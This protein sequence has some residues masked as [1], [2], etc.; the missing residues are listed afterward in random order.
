MLKGKKIVLGV[1]GSIAAYKAVF[2]LRELVKRGADVHV[3]VTDNAKE[4]IAPLTF[5]VLSGNTVFNDMFDITGTDISHIN[6]QEDTDI[7]VV[8]PATAN[9]IGKFA[10]GV[11]DDFLSTFFLAV[12]SPALIAPSMNCNMYNNKIV[13]DNINKLKRF[14]YHFIGPES[15]ELA[16]KKEDIGRLCDIK[17]IVEKVD[18]ILTEKK[19]AG[20]NLFVTA[21]PTVEKIDPVRFISN[22][23][24]GKM[25]YAIA[26]AAKRYGA[27]VT[28]ISGPVNLKPPQGID[29]INVKSADDMYNAVSS[30]FAKND[31]FVMAAAC[32]DFSVESYSEEKIKKEEKSGVTINLNKTVDILQE[33]SKDKDDKV[34]VGFAAESENLQENA[35]KKLRG[36]KLNFIVANDI[37]DPRAGFG[38]DT[39]VVTIIDSHEN[40]VNYDVMTKD[41][42]A[43]EIIGKVAGL[44]DIR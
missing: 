29:I 19:L 18:E 26:K 8:A 33:V 5:K 35:L 32:A 14:G 24:T 28:L 39:N 4:F 10:S 3:I 6:L 20:K 44:F 40:V 1:T 36:K 11:A 16:C 30:H 17:D 15:G 13:Q 21:G 38:T 42:L 34:V 22:R 31:I 41:E 12:N 9:I 23:S 2:L 37:T 25:G 27:N 43:E 7:L